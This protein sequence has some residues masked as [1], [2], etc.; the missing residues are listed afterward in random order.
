MSP[1]SHMP[2]HG[3]FP[4]AEPSRGRPASRSCTLLRRAHAAREIHLRQP[5]TLQEH[6]PG[7]AKRWGQ[8]QPQ[9]LRPRSSYRRPPAKGRPKMHRCKPESARPS[10]WEQGILSSS[11]GAPQ[12][13]RSD[14]SS[15]CRSPPLP[16]KPDLRSGAAAGP[17]VAILQFAARRAAAK[18]PDDGRLL[19]IFL[20]HRRC[21]L[22]ERRAGSLPS[23]SLLQCPARFVPPLQP[24]L[25]RRLRQ[26]FEPRPLTH[27]RNDDDR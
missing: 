8:K 26:R 25:S 6:S 9:R 24:A 3:Q 12:V 14:S 27:R 4:S 19:R 2:R 17:R 11:L 23:E 21:N 18:R 10:V 7:P 20:S 22:Q 13:Q 1:A 16:T 5:P 15:S